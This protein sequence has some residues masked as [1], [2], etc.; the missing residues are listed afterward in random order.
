[1]VARLSYAMRKELPASAYAVPKGTPARKEK[2]ETPRDG[3]QPKGSFP[4]DTAARAH[5]ALSR[6]HQQGRKGG[7]ID[8]AVHKKVA[9]KFPALARRHMEEAHGKGK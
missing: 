6:A 4:V 9:A 7:P 8:A 2:T 3:V 5:N 1:M